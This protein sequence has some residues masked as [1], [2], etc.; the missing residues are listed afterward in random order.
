MSGILKLYCRNCKK[1]IAFLR[2][3]LLRGGHAIWYVLIEAVDLVLERSPPV[4]T[5]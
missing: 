2:S 3:F 4:V 5:G 1:H